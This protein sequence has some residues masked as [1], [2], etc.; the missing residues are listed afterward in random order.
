MKQLILTLTPIF[1][2]S[3]QLFAQG[4][5]II[6]L[7]GDTIRGETHILS[8]TIPEQVQLS[9]AGKKQNFHPLQAKE[10]T[11]NGEIYRSVKNYE[12]YQFMKLLQEGY[13]SLYAYRNEKQSTFDGRL[14]VKKDGTIMDVPNIGFKRKMVSFISEYPELADKIESGE[15]GRFDLEEIIESFNTYISQK[16]VPGIEESLDD[17]TREALTITDNL[18]NKVNQAANFEGK[19]DAKA[20][21]AD[22]KSKLQRREQIPSYLQQAL[23]G[24]MAGNAEL[25]ALTQELLNKLQ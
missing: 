8:K 23:K 11:H 9:N 13:L 24:M 18:L 6:T 3:I 1:L 17:N 16:T 21:L 5:Y 22:I 20:M 19:D 4:D 2:L 10:F 14:M 25:S 7:R 12:T 15:L